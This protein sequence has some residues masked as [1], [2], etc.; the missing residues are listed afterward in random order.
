[1]I[2]SSTKVETNYI[3]FTFQESSAKSTVNNLKEYG[4]RA[5]YEQ[6]SRSIE[7]EPYVEHAYII[8][9]DYV[10]IDEF[11]CAKRILCIP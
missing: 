5:R 7:E 11:N 2:L 1:M 9:I 4:I 8:L 3:D 10:H 6:K